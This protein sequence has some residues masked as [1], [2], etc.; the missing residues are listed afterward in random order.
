MPNMKRITLKDP[1]TGDILIPTG[2]GL[3][4]ELTP[5]APVP[6][7]EVSRD[8]ATLEGH[9]ASYFAKAGEGP[10]LSN[11][12]TKQETYSKTE[13][14]ALLSR[15]QPPSSHTPGDVIW[16]DNKPW[17][18]CHYDSSN[19]RVYIIATVIISM[20][21]FG[22]NVNYAGSTLASVVMNY[23]TTQMSTAALAQCVDITVNDVTAKVFVPSYEQMNGG[24]SWFNNDTN[25]IAYYNDEALNYWTSSASVAS[26]RVRCVRYDGY[27]DSYTYDNSCGLRPCVCVQL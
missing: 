27:I 21:K 1:V 20:T 16:W 22:S 7:Y 26:S 23:Q 14:D 3:G 12:Y 5:D 15:P 18:V 10:D 25:R 19:N 9:P 2:T 8:A 13:V 6:P 11:Y 17:L 4:Y 24:F